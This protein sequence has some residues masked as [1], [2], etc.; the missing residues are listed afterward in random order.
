MRLGICGI[1]TGCDRVQLIGSARTAAGPLRKRGERMGSRVEEKRE[2]RTRC[3]SSNSPRCFSAAYIHCIFDRCEGT[4]RCCSIAIIVA[5]SS[6]RPLA[7]DAPSLGFSCDWAKALDGASVS[8]HTT[9]LSSLTLNL[10]RNQQASIRRSCSSG[11]HPSDL[12]L[13]NINSPLGLVGP[14]TSVL[15]LSRYSSGWL[16]AP[17]NLDRCGMTLFIEWFESEGCIVW[18]DPNRI[19]IGVK[20]STQGVGKV[21]SCSRLLRKV[22]LANPPCSSTLFTCARMDVLRC[23]RI[24]CLSGAGASTMSSWLYNWS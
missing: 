21:R 16:L 5:S 4:K 13:R 11:S 3:R 19:L 1:P 2:R 7:A 22:T 9:L 17:L 14:W 10:W 15:I 8:L 24:C 20:C 18:K 12:A 6:S 23:T